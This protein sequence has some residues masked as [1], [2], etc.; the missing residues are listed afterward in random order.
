MKRGA[1]LGVA[2]LL[3]AFAACGGGSPGRPGRAGTGGAGNA[4]GGGADGGSTGAGFICGTG[5]RCHESTEYCE[6]TLVGDAG[7]PSYRCVAMPIA[8]LE[9]PACGCLVSEHVLSNG[10]CIDDGGGVLT[11]TI[12]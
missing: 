11:V 8:C 3:T 4:G 9:S 6:V 5:P 2:C 7:L 10:Y 12:P 1:L